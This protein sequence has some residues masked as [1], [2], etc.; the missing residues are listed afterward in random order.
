MDPHEQIEHDTEGWFDTSERKSDS[1][2]D[3]HEQ[4]E[5]DTNSGGWFKGT[6]KKKPDS[7]L[8]VEEQIEQDARAG[9]WFSGKSQKRP[10][11]EPQ[12][13]EHIEQDEQTRGSWFTGTRGVLAATHKRRTTINDQIEQARIEV[14]A[15]D[16]PETEITHSKLNLKEKVQVTVL[17]TAHCT[18][19][20][21]LA[22]VPVTDT[23]AGCRACRN[24]W[25]PS[26]NSGNLEPGSKPQR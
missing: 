8:E 6:A 18:D 15:A 13:D 23:Q 19:S 5:Q 24:I 21:S 7:E 11:S 17:C 2:L 1:E 20:Y 4:I 10:D 26:S 9:S 12:V 25:R 14:E 3:P 16:T 22:V